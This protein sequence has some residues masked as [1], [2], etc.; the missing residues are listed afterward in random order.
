MDQ[1]QLQRDVAVKAAGGASDGAGSAAAA[2]RYELSLF[3]ASD[4][5]AGHRGGGGVAAFGM[6]GAVA[7]VRWRSVFFQSSPA[8]RLASPG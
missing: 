4:A 7:L 1:G 2:R 3:V 8:T 6:L 5:G